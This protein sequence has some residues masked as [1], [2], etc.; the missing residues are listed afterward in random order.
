MERNK[1]SILQRIVFTCFSL[2]LLI[3]AFIPTISLDKYVEYDFKYG[4][5]NEKYQSYIE[6]ISTN[7][8]PLVFIQ[9]L[10]GDKAEYNK[11]RSDYKALEK[12]LTTKLQSGA[13]SQEEYNEEISKS[14]KTARYYM[15]AIK[16]GTIKEYSRLKEKV[17]M[18]SVAITVFYAV[19]AIMFII[20]LI[21]LFEKKKLLC[22]AN[23]F[24]GWVLVVLSLIIQF[25]TFSFA[26]NVKTQIDGIDG[27]LFE[28]ATIATSPKILAIVILVALIIYST[29]ALILDKIDAKQE[30]QL[31]EVPKYMTDQIKFN[32]KNQNR[33]RKI[34]SKKSKYK[35]GSKKKR[36]R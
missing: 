20:N 29:I 1:K 2:L 18:F 19:A 14:F 34:N 8:T 22:I 31:K 9:T 12:E 30:R 36:H 28:E 10:F 27:H 35:H 3:T 33:Y 5:Y 32:N 25:F 15:F 16:N 17:F 11:A 4:Y 6:P 24:S 13:I 21:N 26:I 23:V 7:I